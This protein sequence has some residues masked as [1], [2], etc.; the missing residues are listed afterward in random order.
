MVDSGGV[1]PIDQAR[2]TLSSTSSFL[3]QARVTSTDSSG[4]FS[5]TDIPT[6][7]FSLSV[8]TT[9]EPVPL[10]TATRGVVQPPG[11]NVGELQLQDSGS[12]EACVIR[13]DGAT[14][15]SDAFVTVSDGTVRLNGLT[16]VS[17]CVR[18]EGLPLD[19]YI[20][21][22]LDPI[23]TGRATLP[24]VLTLNGQ[25]VDLGTQVL[26]NDIP[27]IVDI[28]P[29]DGTADVDPNTSIVVTLSEFVDAST[30]TDE[31][32]KVATTA[33]DLPGTIQVSNVDPTLTFLPDNPFPD[34]TAVTVTLFADRNLFGQTPPVTEKVSSVIPRSSLACTV[35]S[36][37]SPVATSAWDGG[38]RISAVGG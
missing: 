31:T 35:T 19:N 22:L 8:A 36:T 15:A 2:V 18:F 9:L 33:G 29:G 25:N 24:A 4:N 27:I 21:S 11:V 14:P 7:D 32:F 12:I 10:G 26:D 30:V 34:L 23:S 37:A 20:V 5:F 16:D 38:E 3:T 6:G 28:S 1:D 13:P 17:G